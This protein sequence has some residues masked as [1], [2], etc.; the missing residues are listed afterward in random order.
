MNTLTSALSHVPPAGAYAIVAAAV[1][2]ESVLLIGTFI[3][4]LTLLLTAGVLT[5]SGQLSLPLVIVTAACAVV[6][7][8]FLAYRTGRALGVRL[9]TGRLGRRLPAGAWQRAETL[10]A[11]RG[12]HAVFLARFFPVI[13]TIVPHLAGATR[14]PY[15]RIAPCSLGAAVLWAALEAGTGYA[16]TASLQHTLALGGPAVAAT[17]AAA[18]AAALAW[19]R[20]RRRAR[21]TR[22]P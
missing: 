3:P 18:A 21:V 15:V 13:R 2:A 12:G 19:T 22:T 14:L 11:R 9:R 10:M 6:A 5:R 4:T 8:D 20:L 17:V 16:A 1:L 7:G